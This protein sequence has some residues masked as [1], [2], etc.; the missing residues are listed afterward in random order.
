MQLTVDR[1]DM[2]EDAKEKSCGKTKFDDFLP[3]VQDAIIVVGRATFQEFDRSNYNAI[4][5][6]ADARARY[7][8]L[9]QLRTSKTIQLWYVR[10]KFGVTSILTS[11]ETARESL[12]NHRSHIHHRG[13]PVL[14]TVIVPLADW[15]AEKVT[16]ETIENYGGC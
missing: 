4:H 10:D 12:A 9:S 7:E 15:E 1:E 6:P 5:A 16:T 2:N 14:K 13:E 8:R 3:E 11:A